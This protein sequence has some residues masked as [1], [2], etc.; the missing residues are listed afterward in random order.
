MRSYLPLLLLVAGF[1][2]ALGQTA[3]P[4][5][6]A[7]AALEAWK[8][9]AL[10]FS[11]K[12]DGKDSAQFLSTWK[13]TEQTAPSEG[14]ETHRMIFT[15]PTTQ[16]Q[17]TAEIRTFKDEPAIDWV[18]KFTNGGSAD[19]PIIEDVEPLHWTMPVQKRPV[20]HWANGSNANPDDFHPQESGLPGGHPFQLNSAGGRSSNNNLPFFNL[21]E[22]DHGII[23]AIGWT[24]N[25]VAHFNL[26][27]D[28]KTMAIDAG[29]Q[30]THFLLHAGETV[31]TPRIVML[32]WKGDRGD[33]QNLWRRFVL[34]H[35]SPR[36]PKGNVVTVPLSFGTWGAEPIAT[37]LA[38]IQ[39]LHDKGVALDTYWVDAGWYGKSG[40]WPHERG[41]WVPNVKFYPDGFKPLGDALK[42]AGYGF[43]LWLEAETADP[44]STFLT[45]HPDWYLRNGPNQAL[46][47]LGNPDAL[48][49]MT[50][51]MSN[52]ITEAG[53]T[54]Y[55][56]DFN[57]DPD[58]YWAKNDAPDRVGVTEMEDIAGLYQF[59]DNLRAAHP[60]LQ[61]DNCASGGRRLDIETM[62]RSVSLWRTDLCCGDFNPIDDQRLT[63][64]LNI[65]VP[66]N[67]GDYGSFPANPAEPFKPGDAASKPIGTDLIYALRSAYSAGLTLGSNNRLPLDYLKPLA[68]EFDQVRP[69]FQGDFYPLTSYSADVSTWGAYQL[70]RADLKSGVILAFR[71]SGS[72]YVT[73]HPVLHAI[74]SG[75]QYS[76]EIRTG[77]EKAEAKP[78]SGQDLLNLEISIRDQPGSTLVFYRQK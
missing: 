66:L 2:P 14:G 51:F 64:G 40:D 69:Y 57:V 60:G 41:T 25:W 77:F 4:S 50:D 72:S 26:A 65:W 71:R 62:S 54:W 48:K 17:V 55:R 56:Q 45:E 19:T 76:V 75:A 8:S 67:S 28:V 58:G 47:N 53:M 22:G 3:D 35:Y 42:A 16:L 34:A 11:F 68:E 38:N 1:L 78:M 13:K 9:G 18:L 59:W 24:G 5:S 37:K 6:P 15:D 49:G 12:Y 21:Q 46:L 61:I 74:D 44:G 7:P 20:L 39:A 32:D 27:A 36:D 30:K 31:R 73:L 10:P 70:H 43:I 33:S 52:F 29:M 63:Q 23:G